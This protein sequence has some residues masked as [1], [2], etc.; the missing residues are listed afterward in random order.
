MLN[1]FLASFLDKF[2]AG[3]APLLEHA[4]LLIIS[5]IIEAEQPNV[6]GPDK[7]K[8]VLTEAEATLTALSVPSWFIMAV[9]PWL[10]DQIC[11]YLNAKKFFH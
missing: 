5:L 8:K 9:A 1:N 7:K 3:K 4:V 10:V 11:A 6:A 2:L